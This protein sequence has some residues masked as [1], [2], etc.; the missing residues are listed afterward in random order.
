MKRMNLLLMALAGLIAL[1]DA[2]PPTGGGLHRHPAL[3]QAC[4]AQDTTKTKRQQLRTASTTPQTDLTLTDVVPP[5][6]TAVEIVKGINYPVDLSSGLLKTGVP[7][8]IGP[9][10]LTPLNI[11]IN[12]R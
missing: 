2:V 8:P 6:P 9:R 7:R 11:P 10:L 3:S 5:S 1:A 12:Y 4:T